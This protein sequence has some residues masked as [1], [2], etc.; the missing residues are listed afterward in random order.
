MKKAQGSLEYLIIMA[1]VL[2]IAAVVVMFIATMSEGETKS[3]SVASCKLEASK[4]KLTHYSAPD[5]PCLSCDVACDDPETGEIAL[6]AVKCCKLGKQDMIG[7]N[8][9]EETETACYDTIDN[10]CDG[11]TDDDDP[12][13]H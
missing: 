7:S 6:H 1:A 3:V 9:L 4:C 10:D 8:A 5:D 2:A 13:C 11:L 12:D